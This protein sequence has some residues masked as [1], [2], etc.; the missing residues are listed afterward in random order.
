MSLPLDVGARR[1]MVAIDCSNIVT[2][3]ERG[4]MGVYAFPPPDG[5]GN[6]VT[7]QG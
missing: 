4:M 6:L 7:S 1:V 5:V 3:I 2:S